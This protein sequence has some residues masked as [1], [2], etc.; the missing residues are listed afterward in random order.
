MVDIVVI[1][2]WNYFHL[3]WH[4]GIWVYSGAYEKPFSVSVWIFFIPWVLYA[5]HVEYA[6]MS[7]LKLV[8][9]IG[10]LVYYIFVGRKQ[11]TYT[12]GI[13]H[14]LSTSRTSQ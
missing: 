3:I 7:G 12:G 8:T 10:K 9:I 4:L 13:I 14:L 1:L 5:C 11:P 2:M 6:G